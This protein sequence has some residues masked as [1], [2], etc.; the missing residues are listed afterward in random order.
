M[1]SDEHAKQFVTLDIPEPTTTT[2]ATGN[3]LNFLPTNYD[4]NTS[5]SNDSSTN[6]ATGLGYGNQGS[7]SMGFIG[8]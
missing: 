5:A 1:E 3:Q 8:M 2:A 7:F 4:F 6:D